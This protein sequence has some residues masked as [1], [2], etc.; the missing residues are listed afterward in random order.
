[1]PTEVDVAII[2]AGGVG[3]AIA[4][5]VAQGEKLFFA[6]EKNHTFSMRLLW[7]KN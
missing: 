2:G 3:L 6:F 5:E 4:A 1:M 7:K